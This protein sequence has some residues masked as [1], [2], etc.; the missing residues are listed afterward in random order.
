MTHGIQLDTWYRITTVDDWRKLNDLVAGFH[1]G[2]L[3]ELHW[4][5]SEYVNQE[6]E[7]VYVENPRVWLLVQLQSQETPAVEMRFGG[8]TEC[9]VNAARELESSISIESKSIMFSLSADGASRV[10]AET[11]EYRLRGLEMLGSGPFDVTL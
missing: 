6:F 7:M 1:D 9:T 11:C 2:V 10:V 8:V 4:T 5:H 3:K